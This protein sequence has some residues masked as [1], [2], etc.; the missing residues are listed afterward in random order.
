MND[1]AVL[2]IQATIVGALA[3]A[4]LGPMGLR[5]V[6]PDSFRRDAYGYLT[7]QCGHML[8]GFCLAFVSAVIGIIWTGE[9]QDRF[10]MWMMLLCAFMAF[11]VML[12]GEFVDFVEDVTFTVGYGSG[13]TIYAVK[14]TE[15][16]SFAA[17]S[18]LNVLPFFIA[19]L[20]HVTAG[21]LW[22]VFDKGEGPTP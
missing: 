3:G 9:P 14:W 4:A 12:R 18:I 5:L 19:A 10:D 13:A 21:A 20:L 2:C 1:L 11:E 7:N 15:G 17:S 8:L 16:Y 6:L 22:R